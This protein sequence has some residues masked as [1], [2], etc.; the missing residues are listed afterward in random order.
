MMTTCRLL[1]A[2]LVL[3]LCCCPSV[4]ATTGGEEDPTDH[5]SGSSLE[6]TKKGVSGQ[7]NASATSSSTVPPATLPVSENPNGGPESPGR[8]VVTEQTKVQ[9]GT[10]G[11]TSQKNDTQQPHV[12][13]GLQVKADAANRNGHEQS[14]A[15]GTSDSADPVEKVQ[16]QTP[17]S[18]TDRAVTS[19]RPATSTAG[20]A[21]ETVEE[22]KKS[23]LTFTTQ[24]GSEKEKSQGSSSPGPAPP[25]APGPVAVTADGSDK[26]SPSTTKEEPGRPTTGETSSSGKVTVQ[27]PSEDATEEPENED[28]QE[29]PSGARSGKGE[30]TSTAPALPE[31]SDT[32]MGPPSTKQGPSGSA[33]PT[34][35]IGTNGTVT[36]QSQEENMPN[37]TTTTTTAPEAP[38]TTTTGAPTTTTTGAP[39]RPREIDGS[40][41]S[42]AWVCAPLLLAVSALA[43]TTLG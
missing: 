43:Y 41:S 10:T 2:L 28:G 7:A 31:D 6:Q 23:L 35:Q 1:C 11:S 30:G 8:E 42:S 20:K 12:T 4:N 19:A 34:A 39:S 5:G 37:T 38:S 15:T 3:A 13:S 27:N 21:E 26:I 32:T 36:V 16:E 17:T 29:S 40:L 22:T 14:T 24:T 9:N 33:N 25:E 18:G